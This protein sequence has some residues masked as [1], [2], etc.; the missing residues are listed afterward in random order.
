MKVLCHKHK[1]RMPSCCHKRNPKKSPGNPKNH[2]EI[3]KLSP[4]NPKQSVQ[5][6]SRNPKREYNCIEIYSIKKN[7]SKY[8]SEHIP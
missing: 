4:G 1:E 5:C 2:Q 7:V 3:Q 8:S 6:F